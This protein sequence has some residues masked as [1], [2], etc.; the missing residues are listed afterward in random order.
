MGGKTHYTFNCHSST[1]TSLGSPGSF[2]GHVY[3]SPAEP[4]NCKGNR[5]NLNSGSPLIEH[6]SGLRPRSSSAWTAPSPIQ[7]LGSSPPRLPTYPDVKKDWSPSPPLNSSRAHHN[8]THGAYSTAPWG[9][10]YEARAKAGVPLRSEHPAIGLSSYTA[11]PSPR[12]LRAINS[13]ATTSGKSKQESS[14][15]QKIIDRSQR[16]R[17]CAGFSHFG[18][19]AAP[20]R[21]YEGV[22]EQQNVEKDQSRAAGAKKWGFTLYR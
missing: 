18:A 5:I 15:C 9:S 7:K 14:F 1:L 4:P 17:R 21:L 6:D 11:T 8:S 16:G 10:P 20:L 12:A 3:F 22:V 19:E 13:F 2:H